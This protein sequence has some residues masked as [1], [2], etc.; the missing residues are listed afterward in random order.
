MAIG[1][2]KR[3]QTELTDFVKKVGL[4]EVTIIAVNPSMEEYKT[5]LGIELKEDSKATEY[6]GT[7]QDGNKFVRIDVWLE[8]VKNKTH[9]RVTFFLEDKERENKDA[10]KKQYIN[11]VGVC[12][13]TDDVNKLPDWFKGSADAPRGY[14][15]A[16]TGEEELYGLL[17]T[18]LSNLDYRNA[19]TTLEL[20]WKKLIN[21]NVKGIREQINGEWC[22][23]FIALAT[24]N[25]KIKDGEP[26]EY[27]AIYNKAFLPAYCLRNF[28]LIDYSSPEVL[29]KLKVKK[30]KDLKP[31]ERFVLQVTGEYGSKDYFILKEMKDYDPTD[32]FVASDKPIS[33]DGDDY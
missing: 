33:E 6:L 27:Q 24:I 11:T 18:W 12:S 26:K 8:E 10:S 1:G 30:N 17:R 5:I 29:E 7:S 2:E 14:R 19:E 3:I 25:T 23:P 4:M 21:G 20:E 9:F 28:R 15:V 13:W 16:Y 32:N 31:H 22:A